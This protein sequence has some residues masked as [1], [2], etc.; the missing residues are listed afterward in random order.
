M[1]EMKFSVFMHIL[2]VR[3]LISVLCFNAVTGFYVF[4][5]TLMFSLLY[6]IQL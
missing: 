4:F 2:A 1:S 3:S 6:D 5:R